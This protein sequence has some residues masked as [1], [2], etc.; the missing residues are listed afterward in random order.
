MNL[1]MES[2]YTN[3]L[4]GGVKFISGLIVDDD[5]NSAMAEKQ[6]SYSDPH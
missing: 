3:S 6:W 5:G 2:L 1:S 4:R